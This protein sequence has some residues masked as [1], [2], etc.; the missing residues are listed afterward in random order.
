VNGQGNAG[1]ANTLKI[2]CHMKILFIKGQKS[3]KT[4]IFATY[5]K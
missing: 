5:S 2:Y 4:H 1:K 3:L